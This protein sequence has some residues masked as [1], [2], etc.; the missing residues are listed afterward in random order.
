M[1]K[2]ITLD[3]LKQKN[4]SDILLYIMNNGET[5]RRKIQADTGFSWG[6]VSNSVTYLIEK[7]YVYTVGIL[8]RSDRF[9]ISAE[10]LHH[11]FGQMLGIE[12]EAAVL[13]VGIHRCSDKSAQGLS[14]RL[15]S[16]IVRKPAD[17]LLLG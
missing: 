6:T 12:I 10:Y 2:Y 17:E 1:K 14:V 4:L 11:H 8:G 9:G 7:G 3:N 13:F 16:D 15:I 5:T